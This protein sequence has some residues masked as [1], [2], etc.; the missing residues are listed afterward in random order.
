[1]KLQRRNLLLLGVALGLGAVTLLTQKP[2]TESTVAGTTDL[3]GF[4]EAQVQS[5]KVLGKIASI[6]FGTLGLS[7]LASCHWV[8]V[9][10]RVPATVT[11][12]SWSSLSFTR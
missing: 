12:S 10:V 7:F 5:L 9:R 4:E 2:K 6:R 8:R 1:M 3:F 11:S